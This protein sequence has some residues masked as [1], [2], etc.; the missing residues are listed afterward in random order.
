[1]EELRHEKANL[2]GYETHADF[3]LKRRMAENK[4]RVYKLIDDL[5][6]PSFKK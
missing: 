3:T 4:D 6:I 5:I 2:L 1:M